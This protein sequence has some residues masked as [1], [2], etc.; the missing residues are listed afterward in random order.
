MMQRLVSNFV[1]SRNDYSNSVFARLP[2]TALSPL[3]RAMNAAVRLA[4]GLV[5]RDLVTAVMREL[6]WPPIQLRH[7]I[8]TL[9]TDACSSK[10][11]MLKIHLRGCNPGLCPSRPH[12]AALFHDRRVRCY[13][14]KEMEFRKRAFSVD[15]PVAWNSLPPLLQHLTACSSLCVSPPDKFWY[16]V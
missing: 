8:Q 4:A 9:S 13:A 3:R 15:E 11:F 7:K 6:H 16:S 10:R 2:D 5:S 14:Y 1:L 12:L